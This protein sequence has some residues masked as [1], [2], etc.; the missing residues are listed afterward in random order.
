MIH[1]LLVCRALIDLQLP[2]TSE[3]EDVL[4]ASALCHDIIE[5]VELPENGRELITVFGL[6]PQVYEIVK[7]LSK[8]KDFT[9]EEHLAYFDGIVKNKYALL[10]KLADRSNN[11][12]DLYNMKTWKINEYVDETRERIFPMC[13]QGIDLYDDLAPS[14]QILWEKMVS[15]TEMA[16]ILAERYDK[17]ERELVQ[18][19]AELQNEQISL[20]AEL[21]EMGVE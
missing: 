15:L 17:R 11:V 16:E 2:M 6:D 18:R 5:D 7:I 1:C 12:E 9:E 14:I 21:R 4:F 19:I 8:R 13:G 20:R 3:E 10:I